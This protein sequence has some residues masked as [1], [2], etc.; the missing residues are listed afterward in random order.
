MIQRPAYLYLSQVNMA[1]VT[2]LGKQ[3]A[4]KSKLV[5]YSVI[6]NQMTDTFQ[7]S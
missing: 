6:L 2:K 3:S 4:D 7:E 1:M 5:K